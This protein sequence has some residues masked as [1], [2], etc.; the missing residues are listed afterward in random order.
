MCRWNVIVGGDGAMLAAPDPSK[1]LVIRV[2]YRLSSAN[3]LAAY[4]HTCALSVSAIT[5]PLS[6]SVDYPCPR[7]AIRLNQSLAKNLYCALSSVFA[8]GRRYRSGG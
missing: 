3:P 1:K 2:L 7:D 8:P 4:E 6:K 5:D